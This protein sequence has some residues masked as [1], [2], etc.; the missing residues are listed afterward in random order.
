MDPIQGA[1]ASAE[2]QQAIEGLLKGQ[3]QVTTTR[4]FAEYMLHHAC[5][6]VVD[7]NGGDAAF[8]RGEVPDLP[9]AQLPGFQGSGIQ[10]VED[11]RVDGDNASALVTSV[12]GNGQTH[13]STMR[14]LRENGQWTF[15]N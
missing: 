10:A 14:F 7:Q 12:S 9:V 6:K 15:C 5:Q 1:P 8:D 4:E 2:E 13:T 11:V 3:Y